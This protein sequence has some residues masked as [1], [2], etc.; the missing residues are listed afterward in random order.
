MEN[1]TKNVLKNAW[2]IRALM[3]ALLYFVYAQFNDIDPGMQISSI[4]T[5]KGAHGMYLL[6]ILR[7]F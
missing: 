7:A 4:R 2:R 5:I 6:S 1:K 3:L